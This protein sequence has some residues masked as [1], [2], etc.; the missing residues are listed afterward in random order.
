MLSFLPQGRFWGKFIR[1]WGRTFEGMGKGMQGDL[2][3]VEKMGKHRTVTAFQG[4][5]PALSSTFVA[6]CASVIGEVKAA[7]GS[8]VWYGAVLR[9]DVNGIILGANS[10]IGER[11]VIHTA[12]EK[13]SQS[14]KAQGTT[15]GDDVT[16]GPLAILHA[17]SIANGAT[18][19]A[20]AQVLDGAKVGAGA[21]VEAGAVVSPGTAVPAGEVWGGVPAKMIR[22][23]S[24]DEM[25]AAGRAAVEISELAK[26]HATE[27]SKTWSQLEVDKAVAYDNLTRDPDYNG[28]YYG[29]FDHK[30][31]Y[32]VPPTGTN[33]R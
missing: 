31:M 15:I 4:A 24:A 25:A 22:K 10:S 17:C 32:T 7:A 18:V 21:V 12:S 26:V 11:A 29:T 33:T 20:A 9:G 6:P 5:T 16:V 13:G 28:E 3:Y 19:G 14:G 8:S 30:L 2:A 23:A 1:G 27:S